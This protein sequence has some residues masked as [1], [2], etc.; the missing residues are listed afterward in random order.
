MHALFTLTSLRVWGVRCEVWGVVQLL[1]EM[2]E[3]RDMLIGW[4]VYIYI[5]ICLLLRGREKGRPADV[6]S[7]SQSW[8]IDSIQYDTNRD[9]TI[10]CLAG[11]SLLHIYRSETS[12]MALSREFR[13]SHKNHYLIAGA[14]YPLSLRQAREILNI[15]WQSWQ[16]WHGLDMQVCNVHPH[17]A[18]I[19]PYQ[20]FKY[21]DFPLGN[22]LTVC[23]FVP[24]STRD[25]TKRLQIHTGIL[26]PFF[27]NSGSVR[28]DH[29]GN[30]GYI[31]LAL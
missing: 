6:L 26:E 18:A 23:L 10:S 24:R 22:K 17:P 5:Y 2:R 3:R 8:C 9:C 20:I 21:M 29:L 25:P 31:R 13:F 12:G 19:V 14:F 11:P 15:T 1:A 7:I 4:G 27:V 28:M 16:S 30:P